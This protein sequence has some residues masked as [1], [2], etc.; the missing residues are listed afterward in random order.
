MSLKIVFSSFVFVALAGLCV[1]VNSNARGSDT[2]GQARRTASRMYGQYCIACHGS[3]GRSQTKKG[4]YNHARDLSDAQWQDDVSDER[5]FNSIM[6]GRNIR[7]NMPG[8]KDK[9]NEQEAEA[10]VEYVR[11]FKK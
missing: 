9:L 11:R 8:F 7:G 2:A 6:N 4:K 1:S 3:D 5:M 10:L